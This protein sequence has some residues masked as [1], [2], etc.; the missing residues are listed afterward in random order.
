VK[1]LI[2]LT[3]ASITLAGAAMT[4]MADSG[5]TAAEARAM[6]EKAANALKADRGAALSQIA[7][8][9]AGFKDRDLYAFCGGADGNFSAHPSLI[10]K[11]MRELKSPDGDPIGQKLY[12]AAKEGAISEVSYMWP[13]P[14]STTPAKKVSLVTKVGDQVCG[15]GY[16]Q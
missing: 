7:K 2:A 8:G 6:L 15:V 9:E 11:S 14:G 16:Y 1:K 13:K 12:G 4:A 3:V 10:G 5:G